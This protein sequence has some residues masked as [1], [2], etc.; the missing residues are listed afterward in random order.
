LTAL[1]AAANVTKTLQGEMRGQA[2]SY[3]KLKEFQVLKSQSV[4][5][6]SA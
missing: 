4:E 5:A 1:A 6:I 2:Q 3:E